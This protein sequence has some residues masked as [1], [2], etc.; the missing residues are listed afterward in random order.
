MRGNFSESK[1]NVLDIIKIDGTTPG[2]VIID[3]D[4]YTE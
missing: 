2:D 1:T 3:I 4:R